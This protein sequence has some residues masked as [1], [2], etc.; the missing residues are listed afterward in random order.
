MRRLSQSPMRTGEICPTCA[1]GTPCR[2]SPG[3]YAGWPLVTSQA[4]R[5]CARERCEQSLRPC[6]ENEGGVA[7]CGQTERCR[8]RPEGRSAGGG[9]S[10]WRMGPRFDM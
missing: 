6:D 9:E 10:E 2:T 5:A 4:W 8:K 7:E 1:F 3:S